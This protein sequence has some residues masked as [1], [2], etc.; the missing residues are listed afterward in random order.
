M[1][2]R[3]RLSLVH[4]DSDAYTHF[5]YVLYIRE[6]RKG[7]WRRTTTSRRNFCNNCNYSMSLGGELGKSVC[8]P[9]YTYKLP[10]EDRLIYGRGM[11]RE[12]NSYEQKMR[13]ILS[14]KN[15]RKR[16]HSTV[17]KGDSTGLTF[18]KVDQVRKFLRSLISIIETFVWKQISIFCDFIR[19]TT[20]CRFTETFVENFIHRFHQGWNLLT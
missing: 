14:D 13:L 20:E 19:R 4:Y 9:Y 7:K 15:R 1:R 5:R 3:E 17:L 16:Y 6:L 11:I 10:P 8:P 12:I 2:G 18:E